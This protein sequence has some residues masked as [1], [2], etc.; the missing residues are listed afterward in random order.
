MNSEN[1]HDSKFAE[2]RPTTT[3]ASWVVSSNNELSVQNVTLQTMRKS[4]DSPRRGGVFTI[5][6]LG[7]NFEVKF[8]FQ[9]TVSM[10][11]SEHTVL[12]P[13]VFLSNEAAL[14]FS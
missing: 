6:Y 2:K 5:L 7:K 9:R 4:F 12:T 1:P 14:I 10:E 13:V 11:E 3:S 8:K